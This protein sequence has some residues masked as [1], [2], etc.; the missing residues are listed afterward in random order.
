MALT[1][2]AT[3][4]TRKPICKLHVLGM[5]DPVIVAESPSK[6][7]IKYM[8]KHNPGTLEKTFALLVEEVRQ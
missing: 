4:H 7:S 5:I 3:A 8:V 2:T 6:A 1:V